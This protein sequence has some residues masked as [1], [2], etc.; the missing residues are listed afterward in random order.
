MKTSNKILLGTLCFYFLISAA[1]VRYGLPL[2]LIDDEPPY[3]LAALKMIQL[4][5]LWPAAHLADFRPFLYY[6]PYLAYLYLP[7][8]LMV[9]GLKYAVFKGGIGLFTYYIASHT[10]FFFVLAR[11]FIVLWGALSILAIYTISKRL[12]K[13][14]LAA[15]LSS[16]FL[17]TSLIYLALSGT[18]RQW[19]PVANIYI[20]M[21][22]FLT[23]PNWSY[24]K[25]CFWSVLSIGLGVGISVITITGA[26]FIFLWVYF[27][28][29]YSIAQI[30]KDPFSY[31]C[32]FI[33]ILSG[34][35]PV[36]I[37]PSALGFKGVITLFTHK[38]LMGL[39]ISPIAFLQFVTLSEP[40]LF[41]LFLLG[42][43]WIFKER[44]P[45][46]WPF[47][48][49]MVLYGITFFIFFSY[50]HRFSVSLIPF[51]CILA[52]QGFV[53]LYEY[54]RNNFIFR[55]FILIILMVP[56][57]TALQLGYLSYKN[58]SRII[59]KHWVE[60][61]LPAGSKVAVL[62]PQM[63]LTSDKEAL[64]EQKNIDFNSWRKIDEAEHEIGSDT[65]KTFHA[66][67][68]YTVDNP[69]FLAELPY[70]LKKNGYNYLVVAPYEYKM[71]D[72][73]NSLIQGSRLVFSSG[74]SQKTYSLGQSNFLGSPWMFWKLQTFG[75]YIGVYKL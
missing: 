31:F 56:V 10:E 67:N 6:P 60:T 64:E 48:I 63:R 58:D 39:L 8:F 28:E 53:L 42:I 52:G 61:N 18:S 38:S 20:L 74:S 3:I 43:W 54:T 66:L 32:M 68:L 57:I 34:L 35:L 49:F 2:W 73:L 45:Y 11:T 37:Y 29:K 71:S 59:V 23:Y 26:L 1:I 30:L 75:P 70:Y 17:G 27:C 12:F 19:A 46:A 21:L 69:I 7:M 9:I 47:F 25:R 44:E 33:L 72:S 22:F 65:Y 15:S 41:G 16:F 14:P 40:I 13:N 51:I 55:K 36:V 4:K 24:R 50:E 5:T 62:A